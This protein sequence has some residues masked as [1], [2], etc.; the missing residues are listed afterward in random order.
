[1]TGRPITFDPETVLDSAM[2]RF[3]DHGF[4]RT[5]YGDLVETTGLGRQSLYQAFGDKRSLFKKVLKHYG[6]SVTQKSIDIL[7]SDHPPIENIQCWLDRLCKRGDARLKGCLLT[8]TALEIVPHDEMVA[9]VVRRE[10]A[11]VEKTLVQTLERAAVEKELR[12]DADVQSLSTYLFGVAQGL[13][14]MGRLGLSH[15]KLKSHMEVALTALPLT[16]LGKMRLL[17]K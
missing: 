15:A 9:K 5:S 12:V 16:R 13:M 11:R 1:M 3:W 2:G 6:Q 14:V 10:L 7:N 8:N 17:A 4:E